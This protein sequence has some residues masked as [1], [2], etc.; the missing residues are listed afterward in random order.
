MAL[1]EYGS[2]TSTITDSREDQFWW[3]YVRLLDH[4]SISSDCSRQ[5]SET[6][7]FW[8]NFRFCFGRVIGMCYN[9]E[10]ALNSS[11]K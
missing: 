2:G 11:P 1:L 7:A 9:E 5:L 4:L 10:V 6:I 3:M 8:P